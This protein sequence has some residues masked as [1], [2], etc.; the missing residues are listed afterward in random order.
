MENSTK[1]LFDLGVKSQLKTIDSRLPFQSPAFFNF[2]EYTLNLTHS[3]SKKKRQ[4]QY[5]IQI[6]VW[7]INHCLKNDF[8]LNFKQNADHRKWLL[9]SEIKNC[10]NTKLY[11]A[12][13]RVLL[14]NS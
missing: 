5:N 4:K 12:L 14:I 13:P 11:H 9:K 3:S 7:S 1:N 8:I 10:W 2:R 6:Y